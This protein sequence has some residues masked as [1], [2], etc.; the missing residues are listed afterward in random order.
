MKKQV[1][2]TRRT[3]CVFDTEDTLIQ[4]SIDHFLATC[5]DS[6]QKRKRFCVALS[7]GSTPKNFLHALS[8]SEKA[9]NLDWE[10]GYIFFSDERA[11]P[12]TDDESNYKMAMQFFQDA[13]FN[14]AHFFRMQA[15]HQDKK[16]AA[17]MYEKSIYENVPDTRF[18]IVYLG[19][20]PDGHTASLFPDTEIVDNTHDLVAE[21]YV[22][23]KKSWRMSFTFPLINRAKNIVVLAVGA[24]KAKI[25]REV[26]QK[27]GDIEY[28]AER[29]GTKD[30]PAFFFCDKS[31]AS[32][33][34]Y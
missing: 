25:I 26:L 17:K 7:G 33:C 13:P 29:V 23:A 3:L 18:D 5:E 10:K 21:T 1:I 30:T 31:A 27:T 22:A 11:V 12:P 15:E 20:G 2:D 32:L 16:Q 24:S 19:I 28:P 8:H 34:E 14:K 9:K 4:A 6:V